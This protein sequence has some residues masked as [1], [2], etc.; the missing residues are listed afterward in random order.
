MHGDTVV[1]LV[2]HVLSYL[3]SSHTYILY[4][5]PWQEIL[6]GHFVGKPFLPVIRFP[7]WT[8][9]GN[10]ITSSTER[11]TFCLGTEVPRRSAGIDRPTVD[12]TESTQV[13]MRL[14]KTS[15]HADTPSTHN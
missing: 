4:V 5:F 6:I 2:L 8:N 1:M 10:A 15:S 12:E 7:L 13:R 14:R 11:A 3:W 9:K